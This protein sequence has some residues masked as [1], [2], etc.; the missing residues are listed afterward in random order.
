[1]QHLN[2]H[3][4]SCSRFGFPIITNRFIENDARELD[5]ILMS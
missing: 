4:S 5:D 1:M 3:R 2:G